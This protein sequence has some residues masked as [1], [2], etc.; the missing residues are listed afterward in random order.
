[1]RKT[2]KITREVKMMLDE[3]GDGKTVNQSMELL[4]MDAEPPKEFKKPLGYININMDEELLEKLGNCREYESESYNDVIYR[5]L[6]NH[7]K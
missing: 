6:Q 2:I 4:L 7:Q 3:F 5:L 1:M